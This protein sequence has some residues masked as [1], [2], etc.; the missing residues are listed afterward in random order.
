MQNYLGRNLYLGEDLWEAHLILLVENKYMNAG[1]KRD[2]K[3]QSS[4]YV[5]IVPV[6]ILPGMGGYKYD[7]Y[8][9]SRYSLSVIFQ[10]QGPKAKKINGV[11]ST[12]TGREK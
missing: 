8:I 2:D 10:A 5:C 12:T 9:C 3:V 4:A 11:N 6:R 7:K 1:A